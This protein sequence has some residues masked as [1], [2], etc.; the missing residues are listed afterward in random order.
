MVQWLVGQGSA[1]HVGDKGA[2]HGKNPQKSRGFLDGLDQNA[3]GDYNLPFSAA[4]EQVHATMYAIIADGGRQ[5]KV[6]EGQILD[7]DLRE[8]AEGAEIVF[9]RVLAVSSDAGFRFGQPTVQGARVTASVV[10]P[11]KGEKL[12]PVRFR[13]RKNV[14]KRT[15]HR[16]QYL[17][18]KISKIA[19]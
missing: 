13:R 5:Y 19:G 6:E 8:A 17:R 4:K 15:G 12:N 1:T 11:V 3:P 2:D 18:V 7:I 14:R 10:G 9:E 16:Q